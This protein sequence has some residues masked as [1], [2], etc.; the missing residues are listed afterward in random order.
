MS[1]INFLISK[2]FLKN[3][4]YIAAVTALL[5]LVVFI[6]LN[7]Y[8]HHGEEKPVPDLTGLTQEQFSEILKR[9]ELRYKIID[10]VHISEQ[11]PGVVVDQT[12]GVGENVKR[13]RTIF[14]TI[15]AYTPE[16]VQMPNVV[17]SSLRDA[18]VTLESY[19]LKT[20][21]IIYVPSEYTNLVMGQ[22]FEGKPI[23]K[24]T[25]IIKGSKID[26]LIGKGLSDKKTNVPDLTGMNVEK[27]EQ[28]CLNTSL[29]IGAVICD[30]TI[31][32]DE[33]SLAAFVWQQRPVATEGT[34]LNLGASIDIWISL[35]SAKIIPDTLSVITMPDTETADT[36]E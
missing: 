14:I 20:G 10:S 5:L 31:H 30:T 9:N 23:E 35:D 29:N 26:L 3:L 12:P 32:N 25:M 28:T 18:K 4:G 17:E 21:K 16:K 27:A 2:P 19:G 7:I 11:L 1:F 15:N 33:D 22:M 13:N 8:T 6:G 24:G 36:D 34:K